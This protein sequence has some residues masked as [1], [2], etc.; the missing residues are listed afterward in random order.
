MGSW[1]ATQPRANPPICW[2]CDKRLYGGGRCYDLIAVDGQAD[3]RPVH[4]TC[5]DEKSAAANL[6]RTMSSPDRY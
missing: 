3:P 4:K 6:D 1:K 2:I 5:K